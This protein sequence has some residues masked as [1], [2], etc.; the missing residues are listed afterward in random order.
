MFKSKKDKEFEQEMLIAETIVEIGEQRKEIDRLVSQLS[1]AALEA[2][3]MENND[4]ADEL[5]EIIADFMEFSEDLAAMELE[6]KTCAITAKVMARLGQL[7]AALKA[8]RAVF[9]KA[10]DFT[11][12]GKEFK[13]LRETLAGARKSVRSLR[14]EISGNQMS[15]YEK[16][17]GKKEKNTDPKR[18]QRVS[19]IKKS[20]E[21]RLV[22]GVAK[23]QPADKPATEKVSAD[24]EARI[25]AI[26]A[27]LD[28]ERKD[29]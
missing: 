19:E 17:Y 10:P 7:P 25:D 13:S 20:I 24:D 29:K 18:A 22:T 5:I 11:K 1:D 6:I 14:S 8:C 23:T 4:Y 9:S 15:A 27:M 21:A 16:I 28:E 3:Q 26:A 2:A 12:L